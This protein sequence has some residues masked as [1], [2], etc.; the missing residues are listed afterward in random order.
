[1]IPR[2]EG[3]AAARRFE[4]IE[5]ELPRAWLEPESEV[6]RFELFRKLGQDEKRRILA[7]CTAM[8]LR[9]KLAP[10]SA[11][12]VT[13]FDLALIETGGRVEGYWRPTKANYLGRVTREQL[14][15]IGEEVFGA[16]WAKDR[17]ND[18]KGKLAELLDAAF[19]CPGAEGRTPEQVEKLTTWL[20]AGMSFSSGVE[21]QSAVAPW[22]KTGEKA[23]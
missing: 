19:A 6:E 1:V 5:L 8:A 7:Y 12:D 18:K 20:P 10:A 2:H 3:T 14:L 15:T 21:P 9:P 11:N 23:A 22:V 16:G 13:A 17:R 4:A